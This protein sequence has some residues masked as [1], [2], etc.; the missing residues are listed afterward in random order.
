MY[1]NISIHMRYSS[2]CVYYFVYIRIYVHNIMHIEVKPPVHYA[3][4][5]PTR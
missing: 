2:T 5:K 3:Y 4:I 1:S